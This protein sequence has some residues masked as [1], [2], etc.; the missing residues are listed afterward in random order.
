MMSKEKLKEK[1]A[2]I[3]I[4]TLSGT[5]DVYRYKQDGISY[6]RWGI[7]QRHIDEAIDLY[8]SKG[9]KNDEQ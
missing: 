3:L 8:W 5:N 7:V 6:I 1:I 9:E 4:D 2:T